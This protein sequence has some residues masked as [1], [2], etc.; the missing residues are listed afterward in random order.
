MCVYII[1]LAASGKTPVNKNGNQTET[2]FVTEKPAGKQERKHQ[3]RR[4]KKFR[5]RRKG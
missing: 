1:L 2:A 5:G 3:Q 4:A